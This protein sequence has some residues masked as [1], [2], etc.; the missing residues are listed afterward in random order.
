MYFTFF[1]IVTRPQYSN[2]TTK[3]KKTLA[4]S[5]SLSLYNKAK[6]PTVVTR[7]KL[8]TSTG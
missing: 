3:L 6:P 7:T 5:L 1:Q 2:T 4:R 8:T